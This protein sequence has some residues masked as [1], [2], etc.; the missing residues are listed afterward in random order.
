MVEQ[1]NIINYSNLSSDKS[2]FLYSIMIILN[3]PI[4]VDQYKQF[5]R[6]SDYIIC[7]DG[8]ANRLYELKERHK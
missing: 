4:I 5:R 2:L 3:R 6:I 1:S 8:A 7:A